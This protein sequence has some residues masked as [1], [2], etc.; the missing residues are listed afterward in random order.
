MTDYRNQ[1]FKKE[2]EQECLYYFLDAYEDVTGR[3]IEV[4]ETSERPDFIYRREDIGIVGVELVQVR[5]GHPD[6]ILWDRLVEKQDYMSVDHALE[7]LQEVSL[8]KERKRKQADWK[9]P[10]AT[11]LV[12]EL[13]DIPLTLIE[14]LIS[15]ELLPDLFSSTGFIEVWI[16][17]PT[18]IKAYDNVELFCV[19]PEKWMGYT[20]RDHFRSPTDSGSSTGEASDDLLC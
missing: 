9:L 8:E 14:R 1:R 16:V 3:P 11:I 10:A 5:R 4:L 15:P 2:S 19:R 13:S 7:I 12:V 6:D 17:D 20:I 18:G